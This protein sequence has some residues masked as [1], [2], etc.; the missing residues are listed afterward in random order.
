MYKNPKLFFKRFIF[1]ALISVVTVIIATILTGGASDFS[2]LIAFVI[3]VIDY[4]FI[5]AFF[6]IAVINLLRYIF[7]NE[8]SESFMWYFINTVLSLGLAAVFSIF[9]IVLILGALTILLPFL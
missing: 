2:I 9:Y 4:L 5:L 1:L 6:V 8:K 3:V 7:S